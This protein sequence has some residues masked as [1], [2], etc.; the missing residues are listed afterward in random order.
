MNT[1]KILIWFSCWIC[2]FSISLM[3]KETILPLPQ[4]SSLV[5]KKIP[6]EGFIFSS[7]F[8]DIKPQIALPKIGFSKKSKRGFLPLEIKKVETI[9][10]AWEL[11]KNEAYRLTITHKK[12]TIEA[13][14]S[15]GAFW[16]L[17]TLRQLVE[18]LISMKRQN[19]SF[20]LSHTGQIT[21]YPA[22]P[23]RGWMQDVG[24][25]YIPMEELKREIEIMSRYKMNVF[26]WHLTEN[27]GWR[28]ES[29]KYPELND[30]KTFERMHGQYYTIEEA[31]ELAQF[32]KDR[33][34]ILLPEIDMPGHSAAFKKAFKTD[35]QSEKGMEILQ[36]L[37]D[38]ALTGAFNDHQAVPY[39]HIGTDE[40]HISNPRFVPEMVAFVRKHGKKV[41]S[42]HPGANYKSG[43]IDMIQMWSSRGRPLQGTPSVD[44]RFHYINHF[45]S[46]ADLGVLFFGQVYAQPV[47]TDTI[48]GAILAVWHDRYV[49]NMNDLLT[50]NGV[51]PHLLTLAETTWQG[52]R[53]QSALK[54]GAIL[55]NEGPEWNE[56]ADFERRLMVQRR[57]LKQDF[58]GLPFIYVPQSGIH[59]RITEA[60]P[61]Q[62]D[63]AKVFPPEQEQKESY[64]YEG[65]TYN[66]FLAT[67]AGIYLRHTWGN[68]ICGHYKN[69][70]TNH[71]AYAY[72]YIYSPKKQ[73]VGL[74]VNTQNY[75]RSEPDLPPPQGKWDYWG[76][77]FWLNDKEIAPPKWLNTHKG[78][79]QEVSLQNENFEV[80]APLPAVLEKGWNKVL[81][82][83]PMGN[84]SRG[85]IRLIKWMF[86]FV[87]VT[88]KG[89]PIQGLIYSPDKKK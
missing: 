61:N 27:L 87:V 56:F 88:P 14:T 34:M 86:T 76:S 7:D 40:V 72:T 60:F 9:E 1:K 71:T 47:A 5:E 8:T 54:R 29:K 73:Q 51:Y 82:K 37:L 77:Q 84:F 3:A 22:F 59:W 25:S 50:S 63:F 24:R 79:S 83:L 2:F 67:G 28:L 62:G 45:D 20:I 44:C 41:V 53:K 32:C 68:W 74:W 26:H 18:P 17:Q 48:A 57:K 85:E 39:L 69:A 6:F 21:D 10:G 52:K 70:K 15:Q 80:R 30:K 12:V 75:S 13:L 55:P 66:T 35:M 36:G 42:W 31:K 46:F 49:K 16:G 89:E 23:I 4:Q 81:I 11:T 33:H 38:E 19:P 64:D 78:K 43:E 58:P 65:K